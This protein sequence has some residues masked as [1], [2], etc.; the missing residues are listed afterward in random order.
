MNTLISIGYS[1]LCCQGG[2]TDVRA[3]LIRHKNKFRQVKNRHGYAAIFDG[4][5]YDNSDFR[6]LKNEEF[7][8]FLYPRKAPEI[9]L[10]ESYLNLQPHD[11][12]DTVLEHSNPHE[13]FQRMVDYGRASDKS[14]ARS[15]CFDSFEQTEEFVEFRRGLREFLL[16]VAKRFSAPDF[17]VT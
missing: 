7:V 14:D 4:D 9:F 5:M 13:F 10:L 16:H 11:G 17:D 12:L 6:N 15:I 1:T 3:D 8:H 2:A